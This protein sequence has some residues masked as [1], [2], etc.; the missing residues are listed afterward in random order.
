METKDTVI[1]SQKEQT[2]LRVISEVSAGRWP[3]AEAAAALHISERQVRRLR[4][5][6]EV[7]GAGAFMHGNRGLASPHRLD[8]ALKARVVALGAGRYAACNDSHFQEL[9]LRDEGIQLSRASIQRLRRQAGQKPKQRRRLPKHR[10]RRDRRPR[11]GMLLQLDGSRHHWFGGGRPR[12]CLLAAI[13]DATGKVVAAL[14]REQEDAQG[15]FLLL[16]QVLK[17]Q[18]I[19]IE[20]YHDRHSIFQVN[21]RR[22]ATITEE[23]IDKREPTQFGRALDELAIISIAAQSPEAKGR[24]ERLWGTWQDRLVVELDLAEVRDMASGNRFLTSYRSRHNSQFAIEP[25]EPSVAYRSLSPALD[26]DSILSFR[27]QRV[28]ARDNTVRLE[29]HLV[30]I[31]P[32]PRQRSYAGAR[33]WVHEFLDGSL[34]VR[35]QDGWLVRG[36]A[37]KLDPRIKARARGRELPERPATPQAVL[38]LRISAHQPASPTK[39]PSP[40]SLHPWRRWTP[41]PARTESRSS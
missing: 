17:A 2:R 7:R 16:R 24:I 3:V 23:L 38:P 33:V 37:S 30:Q 6:F 31:P 8:D 22:P 39:S 5:G 21:P 36:S 14:F 20:L 19:P 27:Y 12:C 32:G 26:L 41:Q 15:Y 1:L 28:V 29:G 13:D 4:Q 9:L 18:G 10:S 34:G 11:E 40:N 35:Y 25:E